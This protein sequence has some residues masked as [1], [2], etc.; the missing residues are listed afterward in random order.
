MAGK[1]KSAREEKVS[2]YTRSRK[3]NWSYCLHVKEYNDI[4]TLSY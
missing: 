2:L 3:P 4:V 1:Q